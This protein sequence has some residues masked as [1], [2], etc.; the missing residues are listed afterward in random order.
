MEKKKMLIALLLSTFGSYASAQFSKELTVE[1]KGLYQSKQ[2]ELAPEISQ[3]KDSLLNQFVIKDKYQNEYESIVE[4][5]AIRKALSIR[6][7][8]KKVSLSETTESLLEDYIKDMRKILFLN[9]YNVSTPNIQLAYSMR[10]KLNLSEENLREIA[11]KAADLTIYSYPNSN[12]CWRAELNCLSNILTDKQMYSFIQKRNKLDIEEKTIKAWELL[13]NA[14]VSNLPKDSIRVYNYYTKR[15]VADELY[16]ENPSMKKEAYEGIRLFSPSVIHS[17]EALQRKQKKANSKNTIKKKTE[18]TVSSPK[19]KY[20]WSLHSNQTLEKDRE[21][22][23]II[24]QILGANGMIERKHSFVSLKDHANTKNN[25]T[26]MNALAL[27]YLKGYGTEAD[28]LSALNW[29]K[30]AGE[31]GCSDAYNNL[32]IF[33][34]T[35]SNYINQEK[36][37]LYF[38]KAAERGDISGNYFTGY[39]LY[40][41]IGCEQSY[42]KAIE[43]FKIGANVSY[44]P[45]LYML[46]L[47][48]RN[49]YGVEQNEHTGLS[50]LRQAASKSYKQALKELELATPE[51]NISVIRKRSLASN[52]LPSQHPQKILSS[53]KNNTFE[54]GEY[55]GTLVTYDWS[56]KYIIEE[57][58][59]TLTIN[60]FGKQIEG[61]WQE[62]GK[63]AIMLAANIEGSKLRFSNQAKKKMGKY[64]NMAVTTLFH[65]ADIQIIKNEVETSL[66]GTL[67]MYSPQ[68]NEKERPMYIH[69]TLRKE[70]DI[71]S[72][73]VVIAYPNPFSKE[74][75]LSINMDKDETV[76][77]AIY[78]MRGQNVYQYNAGVLSTG[79]QHIAIQPNLRKGTYIAK[80]F[81]GEKENQLVIIS[82]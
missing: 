49:G 54:D 28:T 5:Y 57:T 80:V 29:W 14:R 40:K 26:A 64:K 48:Y 13:Q 1:Q 36:S 43:H 78:D 65:E 3:F 52:K 33:Y 11:E 7:I 53:K 56:G 20:I 76:L 44:A 18:T 45:S 24:M 19:E 50:F 31:Q 70:E 46:G 55:V 16:A 22:Q 68:T 35:V 30:K 8:D 71:N 32:G 21:T 17:L 39:M 75:N 60:S 4:Y 77:I 27:M 61:V 62:E 47:C 58:P 10:K 72:N 15:A 66:I 41:G 34:K 82:K 42:E 67:E 63:E 79:K 81:I 23:D 25:A 6:N 73:K 9:G 12:E 51:N 69:L 38:S 37:F 2:T 74:L 59:L